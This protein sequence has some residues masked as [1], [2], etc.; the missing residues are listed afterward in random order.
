MK[1][2]KKSNG[3]MFMA[4]L[5]VLACFAIFLFQGS[6]F[7]GYLISEPSGIF[8]WT[9]NSSN[10]SLGADNVSY[11][12]IS[13][14]LGNDSV[15]ITWYNFTNS[16]D[17]LNVSIFVKG[18]ENAS[19]EGANFTNLTS[20][21]TSAYIQFKIN[22]VSNLSLENHNY[23]F[24]FDYI[25]ENVSTNETNQTNQT[26]NSSVEE[27][28]DEDNLDLCESQSECDDADGYWYNDDEECLEEEPE[29]DDDYLS[30][31]DNVDDCLDADGYWYDKE[32]HEDE[33]DD[34]DEDDEDNFVQKVSSCVPKFVCGEWGEC[35]N[36]SQTRICSDSM[37]CKA[38]QNKT[39]TQTC[40]MLIV[41]NC[42]D[43]IKNQ[44]EQGVD[45]GGVCDKKCGSSI[46]GGVISGTTGTVA[47]VSSIIIAIIVAGF[48]TGRFLFKKKIGIA[49]MHHLLDKFLQK[50]SV[51]DSN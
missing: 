10:F 1:S 14:P 6:K 30:F 41:E 49:Q 36:G 28:C 9:L 39:E 35:L 13:E 19:C 8:N 17:D 44:D 33:E 43:G 4:A 25:I 5:V 47:I 3:F 26:I 51:P 21:L 12:Y 50:K 37:K 2:E 34:D 38:S 48:F 31:C 40:E 7:T 42:E 46:T 32:C 24:G 11:S 16:S 23:S 45:C 29:C 20:N 27:E 18:C 15:N 22:T